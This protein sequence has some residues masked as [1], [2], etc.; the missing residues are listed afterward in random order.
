M[1]TSSLTNLGS[2]F[3]YRIDALTG[4]IL[5]ATYI[6]ERKFF[7]ARYEQLPIS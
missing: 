6:D 4:A 3:A 1:L 5:N 7:F 2:D